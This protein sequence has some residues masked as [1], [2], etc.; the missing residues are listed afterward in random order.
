MDIYNT[1]GAYHEWVSEWWLKLHS[2]G[3]LMLCKRFG[4]LSWK[5]WTARPCLY[6]GHGTSWLKP[7]PYYMWVT[8]LYIYTHTQ[9][10]MQGRRKVFS[11]WGRG[12]VNLWTFHR[13]HFTLRLDLLYGF[14][15]CMGGAA[16]PP[17][18]WTR[19]PYSI[20]EYGPGSPYSP[21]K[22]GPP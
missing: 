21:V 19:G 18:I 1:H 20:G 3:L 12:V 11:N 16:P 4:W 14:R 9:W 15:K 7:Q 13:Q 5:E 22:Y 2:I 8:N 6:T 17:W 10:S